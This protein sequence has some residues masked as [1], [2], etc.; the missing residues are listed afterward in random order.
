MLPLST[1]QMCAE[2]TAVDVASA[3]EVSDKQL[4]NRIRSFNK[5]NNLSMRAVTHTAQNTR[6]NLQLV[7][8]F[9]SYIVELCKMY[10]ID[11]ND[12]C[13]FDETNIHFS[14]DTKKN[15][16]TKRFQKCTNNQK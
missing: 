14:P 16:C 10:H 1:K 5:Q 12:V 4:Q 9:V 15:I 8:G 3:S 11:I 7:K 13:N 2:Y 6:N